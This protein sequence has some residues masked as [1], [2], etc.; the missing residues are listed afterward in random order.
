[1]IKNA[2]DYVRKELGGAALGG[3]AGYRCQEQTEE[4]RRRGRIVYMHYALVWRAYRR[5]LQTGALNQYF[6]EHLRN[7][8]TNS[9]GVS[10]V[11]AFF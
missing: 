2:T 6:L 1:M 7:L 8:S 4:A 9:S 10:S 3:I 5:N 11:H